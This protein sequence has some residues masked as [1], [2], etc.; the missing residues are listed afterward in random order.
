MTDGKGILAQ[1]RLPKGADIL[2]AMNDEERALFKECCRRYRTSADLERQY[3]KVPAEQCKAAE[4]LAAV[5][6]I[7]FR[8]GIAHLS[9][10]ATFN[11]DEVFRIFG[12]Q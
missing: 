7:T 4:A 3:V 5:R 9:D 10:T 12:D 6:L 8:H 2:S 11:C 1:Q